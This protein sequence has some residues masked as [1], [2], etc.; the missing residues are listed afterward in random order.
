LSSGLKTEVEFLADGTLILSI[1]GELDL[2]TSTRFE[3]ELRA[4]LRSR[5]PAVIL[6]LSKCGFL[7]CSALGALVRADNARGG[8]G[9]RFSL[10]VQ[11]RNVRAVFELTGL[12]TRF[13][14]HP[15]RAA[16]APQR[17]RRLVDSPTNAASAVTARPRTLEMVE[18]G[19]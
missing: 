3:T 2:A 1:D 16:A 12:D 18:L 17:A 5:A 9:C 19:L 10:V 14:L 11:H 6:D 15:R 13:E 8:A 4:A 7:D